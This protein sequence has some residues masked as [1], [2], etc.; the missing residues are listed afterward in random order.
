VAGLF[1][2]QAREWGLPAA[3]PL[4]PK[5]AERV[6]REGATAVFDTAARAL[7]MDWAT[8]YDGKQ[9]QRWAEK[10]GQE[11][12]ACRQR[13]V[14]V[15]PLGQRPTGPANDSQL[16]VI[17]MDGGRVQEREKDPETKSHWHED[18]IASISTFLPGNGKD[19][20]PRALVT[21]YV[22][23]MQKAPEFGLLTRI[24]AERRGIRQ[25]PRVIVLGDGASFID[26]ICEN[27]FGC[28]VRI[29]DY[30][31]AAEH[32]AACIKAIC[33][34]ESLRHKRLWERWREHLWEGRIPRIIRWL[35]RQSQRLGAVRETDLKEHPRRV[36]AENLTYF[37]RHGRQMN[38][39]HYRTNGWPIGSGLIESTVK[40]FNKRVK[41][42]E[43]FWNEAGAESILALRALWL[44]QDDRWNH[45]WLRHQLPRQAA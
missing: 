7:N 16:L 18:K 23:T 22:A 43:Q 30:Y 45:Y 20:E 37:D 32:L 35:Q 27:H 26:T 34:E 25:A 24:E 14:Q 19:R 10:I 29:V 21:T 28:H 42:T 12:L 3:L 6:A 15:Y 36:I 2:P 13:E 9:V 4:T 11:V 33:P 1:P 8:H 39:P 31:H 41:G 38:Y 5:A 44:S 40:Q 17:E